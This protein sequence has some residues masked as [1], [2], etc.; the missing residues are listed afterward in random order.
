MRLATNTNLLC[1]SCLDGLD[2]DGAMPRHDAP[3]FQRVS[4]RRVYAEFRGASR[5]ITRLLDEVTKGLVA[6]AVGIT[7][8]PY[9][10]AEKVFQFFL[11]RK[12]F[13]PRFAKTHPRQERMRQRMRADLVPCRQPFADLRR[14]HQRLAHLVHLRLPLVE[15]ADAIDDE[16]LYRSKFVLRQ[17]F[18]R[19]FKRVHKTIVQ[20]Q[21]KRVSTVRAHGDFAVR[22]RVETGFSQLGHLLLK[23]ARIEVKALDTHVTR[24]L[25]N[26][27]VRETRYAARE[28]AAERL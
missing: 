20:C 21:R 8:M 10:H 13:L 1:Q 16:K 5:G 6:I 17:R 26:F 23:Q 11:A 12:N 25:G 19:L 3:Q 27:V 22:Q 7:K 18:H 15:F 24:S 14:I 28:Q 2:A 4:V 9:R